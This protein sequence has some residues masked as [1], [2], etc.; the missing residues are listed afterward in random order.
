MNIKRPGLVFCLS[1]GGSSDY[2]QP[3]AG[4][5]TEVT[6]PV[7]GQTLSELTPSKRQKTSPG[8]L[9]V[10]NVLPLVGKLYDTA[11]H[12]SLI[13]IENHWVYDRDGFREIASQIPWFRAG[14]GDLYYSLFISWYTVVEY[15][16]LLDT[17]WHREGS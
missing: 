4:Q 3:I 13:R 5:V 17:I 16:K 11:T 1:L 15:N 14:G 2:A 8:C 12:I 9:K 10:N 6:C 7:I